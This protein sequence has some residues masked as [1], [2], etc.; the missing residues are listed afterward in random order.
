MDPW[1][2]S[3]DGEKNVDRAAI[4]LWPR[5]KAFEIALRFGLDQALDVAERDFQMDCSLETRRSHMQRLLAYCENNPHES[6]FANHTSKC[7]DYRGEMARNVSLP[8][9]SL[10]ALRLIN[11]CLQWNLRDCGLELIRLLFSDFDNFVYCCYN[12]SF[13]SFYVPFFWVV[14]GLMQL[15]LL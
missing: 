4:I 6:W 9:A 7:E 2:G 5:S 8:V 1:S 10:R 11:F 12:C 14:F 13:N 15:L 3:G